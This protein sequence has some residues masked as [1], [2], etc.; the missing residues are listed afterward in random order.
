MIPLAC[1]WDV[2]SLHMPNKSTGGEG[3]SQPSTTPTEFLAKLAYTYRNERAS[4]EMLTMLEQV[5]DTLQREI[6]RMPLPPRATDQEFISV[7][8]RLQE[9]GEALL[10]VHKCVQKFPRAKP[11]DAQFLAY[12]NANRAYKSWLTAVDRLYAAVGADTIPE[13]RQSILR[14]R[15]VAPL[16]ITEMNLRRSGDISTND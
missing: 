15:I 4:P 16:T 3:P 2:Y 6:V 13:K 10:Y 1:A 8:R 7:S 12:T 5:A 14:G 9:I 11:E